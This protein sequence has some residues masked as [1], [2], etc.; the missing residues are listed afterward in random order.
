M[1]KTTTYFIIFLITIYIPSIASGGNI[2]LMIPKGHP[3]VTEDK[4]SSNDS[5][6]VYWHSGKNDEKE[7]KKGL[8][9]IEQD[10]DEFLE[11][12]KNLKYK[13]DTI[14]LWIAGEIE[15]GGVTK[16]FVSVT[17]SGGFKIVLKP[18]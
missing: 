2:K 17:G 6:G 4:Q 1:K 3:I 12:F 5:L 8:E 15:S 18:E 16:L 10:L 14:E 9:F 7:P 11:K 13:V